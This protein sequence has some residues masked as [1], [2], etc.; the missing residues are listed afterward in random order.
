MHAK[1]YSTSKTIIVIPPYGPG[2][3][4]FVR[5]SRLPV[6]DDIRECVYLMLKDMA[7]ANTNAWWNREPYRVTVRELNRGEYVWHVYKGTG[8]NGKPPVKDQR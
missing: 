1:A 6:M 8:Q 2:G 5:H 4:S 3:R 7:K